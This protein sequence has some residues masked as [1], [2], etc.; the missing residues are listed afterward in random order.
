ML[1]SIEVIILALVAWLQWRAYN[2]AK[3]ALFDQYNIFPTQQKPG[4]RIITGVFGVNQLES[5]SRD[6]VQQQIKSAGD[7]NLIY[8]FQLTGNETPSEFT[9]I[10]L[11]GGTH[12]N[13]VF[14]RIQKDINI[15]LCRNCNKSTDFKIIQDIIERHSAVSTNWGESTISIPL[16]YGLLGTIVGI[17]LGSFYIGS[18]GS[19]DSDS[20]VSLL[21]TVG[22]AMSV[23]GLGLMLT[24]RNINLQKEVSY[25]FDFSKNSFLIFIQT[26]LMPLMKSDLDQSLHTMQ[27]SLN[28]FNSRFQRN[29]EVFDGS[30]NAIT[31][32][33][34]LQKTFIQKLDE[35][36]FNHMVKETVGIF[37]QLSRSAESLKI[38]RS[39]Q[40]SMV[41]SFGQLDKTVD[42]FQNLFNRTTNFENSLN[43]IADNIAQQQDTYKSLMGMLEQ[44][45]SEIGER[46]ENLRIIMDEI[47][48]FFRTQYEELS[49]SSQ[50]HNTNLIDLNNVHISQIRG[51]Y[52]ELQHVV[53]EK[54]ELMKKTAEQEMKSLDAIYNDKK[55][56]FDS[57]ERIPKIEQSLRDTNSELKK[58]DV[59]SALLTAITALNHHMADENKKKEDSSVISINWNPIKRLFVRSQN[60]HDDE[61]ES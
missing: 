55:K 46:K 44:N 35:I 10:K 49:R 30:L 13:E 15:Y 14:E 43:M 39:Y 27:K 34:T 42:G 24:I 38:F 6:F 58:S 60:N 23:S 25:S 52:D 50:I 32:N 29:L 37:E 21:R 22:L 51:G 4:Y 57:L 41:Q 59:N 3:S 26:E 18:V 8:F 28:L 12:T 33:L 47:H 5:I 7:A 17:I 19:E 20:V 40:E 53:H 11:L 16:Y 48:A 36:G 54:I 61:K 31:E 2:T 1:T 45:S 9:E 56:V